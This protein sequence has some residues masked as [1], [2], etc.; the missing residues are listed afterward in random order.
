VVQLIPAD[1]R[2]GITF[3]ITKFGI[4]KFDSVN[5]CITGTHLPLLQKYNRYKR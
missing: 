2:L 1:M 3:G 5:F 4:P